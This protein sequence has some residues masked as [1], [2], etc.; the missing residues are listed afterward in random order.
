[1]FKL[2][3]IEAFGLVVIEAMNCGLPTLATN[4]GGP[5]ETIVDGVSG[6]QSDP[7]NG[8]ES[9]NRIADFFKKCRIDAKYWNKMSEAGL[10]R[11][12]NGDFTTLP[13]SSDMN[14]SIS[15]QS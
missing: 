6:S 5:A 9:R 10:Q 11:I 13:N 8:D 15:N 12:K 7:K 1:M 14:F 2:H 4:Q 3:S